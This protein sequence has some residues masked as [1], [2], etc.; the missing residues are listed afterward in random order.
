MG[1]L[2]SKASLL[3]PSVITSTSWQSPG[4]VVVAGGL[5]GGGGYHRWGEQTRL[6]GQRQQTFSA[7]AARASPVTGVEEGGEADRAVV[8]AGRVR[9]V[10]VTV[11]VPVT[12]AVH[13]VLGARLLPAQPQVLLV[14]GVAAAHQL[15]QRRGGVLAQ[16]GDLV[17]PDCVAELPGLLLADGGLGVRGDTVLVLGLRGE[18]RGA[19]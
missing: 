14:A 8:R 17:V 15:Q 9:H 19:Q 10:T 6:G 4:Q 18:R 12:D 2:S 7:A 5:P 13:D 3:S 11:S 1:T 16:L